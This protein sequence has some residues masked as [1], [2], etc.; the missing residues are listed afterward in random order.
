MHDIGDFLVPIHSA[1]LSDDTL[2]TNG[3]LGKHISKYEESVPELTDIDIVMIG[4]NEYRGESPVE[5]Q[6]KASDLVRKALYKL[7]Y[8]HTDI[9]I[10]DMGD[11]CSGASLSD[12]YA[13]VKS[14]LADLIKSGKKVILLGGSHDITLAQYGAYKDLQM[15]IEAT[16]VDA[17]IDLKGESPRKSDSFLLEMLTSE[18]NMVKH[19]NHIGFQSYFVHPGLLETIDKLRFDCFRVGVVK[20]DIQEMEPVIR[21]SNMLS[22][23][24]SAIKYSDA[25]SH[26]ASVNGLSGE[27]A[28]TLT[29][30]AGW[31]GKLSTLGIFGYNPDKDPHELSAAQIAQMIWYFI[32]GNNK[33]KQEAGP[34]D[35][36]Q[37]NEYHTAFAEIDTVFLQNRRTGRWWMQLPNK[38]F[39]ACSPKDYKK[40]CMDQ[41]PER[42]LRTLERSA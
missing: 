39:T 32:D 31:S 15:T 4:V 7:H 11:V 19:Y 35:R 1:I 26:H 27:E 22:F 17:M 33:L 8:W 41:I 14:V 12:T 9:R 25:P 6:L 10:A 42:W 5:P 36:T 18:P 3:Q 16:C 13:A 23:D 2:Y 29:Q 37:Y 24:L 40:A 30:Y 28:C 38:Q 21:N 20:E 34:E